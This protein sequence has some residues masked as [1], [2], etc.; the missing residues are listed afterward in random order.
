MDGLA[1]LSG[2]PVGLNLVTVLPPEG[3]LE[4]PAEVEEPCGGGTV[5]GREAEHDGATHWVS[6]AGS[7]SPC[8]LAR[9]RARCWR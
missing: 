7:S 2:P 1:R 5:E 6:S 9:K 4:L 8:S 3:R